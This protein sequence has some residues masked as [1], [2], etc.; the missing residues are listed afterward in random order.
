MPAANRYTD[1]DPLPLLRRQQALLAQ[2][3]RFVCRLDAMGRPDATITLS[4][5]FVSLC[6]LGLPPASDRSFW[7]CGHLVKAVRS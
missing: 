3:D 5:D 1:L 6:K 7:Y 4:C 2:L